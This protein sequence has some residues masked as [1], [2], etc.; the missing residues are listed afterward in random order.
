MLLKFGATMFC[1][2]VVCYVLMY[3][4]MLKTCVYI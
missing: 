4:Y 3:I 2:V 1:V